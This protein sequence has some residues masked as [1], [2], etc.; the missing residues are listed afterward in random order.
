ANLINKVTRYL[1]N[2]NTV[3][4]DIQILPPVEAMTFTCQHIKSGKDVI[5]VTGNV[6]RDYLTDLFPILE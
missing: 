1:A 2:H 4:L 3:G 6:L 5:S